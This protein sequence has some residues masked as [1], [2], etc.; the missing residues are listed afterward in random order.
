ML[1]VCNNKK[2]HKKKKTRGENVRNNIVAILS[3]NVAFAKTKRINHL[4]KK[5]NIDR[6]VLGFS[7]NSLESAK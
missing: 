7:A 1:N 3:E 4:D 5:S 6:P 2:Q